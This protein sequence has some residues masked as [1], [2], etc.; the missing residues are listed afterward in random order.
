MPE[1]ALPKNSSSLDAILSLIVNTTD[2]TRLSPDYQLHLSAPTPVPLNSIYVKTKQLNAEVE[3]AF[4]RQQLI[5]T[6][7]FGSTFSDAPKPIDLHD[8]AIFASRTLIRKAERIFAPSSGT[9]SIPSDE[10]LEA[11]DYRDPRHERWHTR[12]PI[13]E[14]IPIDLDR[15]WEHLNT[16]YGGEAGRITGYKQIAASL[17]STFRITDENRIKKTSSGVTLTMSIYSERQT[18]GPNIGQLKISYHNKSSLTNTFTALACFAEWAELDQ[19]SINLNP[20]RHKLTDYGFSYLSRSAHQFGGLNIT[21]FTDKWEFKL[22]H[23]VAQ[24]LMLFLGE[25][26]I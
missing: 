4:K 26:G 23:S 10:V 13:K 16:T 22:S 8:I 3:Q 25:F 18:Y 12:P 6:E 1:I 15:L 9:L 7:Y 20:V 19:L 17:I 24:K 21:M 14:T 5:E 11:I 2:A